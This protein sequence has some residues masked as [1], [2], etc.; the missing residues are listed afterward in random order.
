LTQTTKKRPKPQGGTGPFLYVVFHGEFAF[1]DIEKEKFLMALAPALNEHAYM[2]GPWLGEVHIPKGSGLEL[3]GVIEE[4]RPSPDPDVSILDGWITMFHSKAVKPT[5]TKSAWM[6]IKLPRP[7][8]A[9]GYSPN[10]LIPGSITVTKPKGLAP[11]PPHSQPLVLILQYRMY[12]GRRKVVP[13]LCLVSEYRMPAMVSG[14]ALPWVAG[15]LPDQSSYSLHIFGE[16]DFVPANPSQ[17]AERAFHLA[18]ALMGVEAAEE[19]PTLMRKTPVK[20]TKSDLCPPL[21]DQEIS[22]SLSDRLTALAKLATASPP[23][24]W[25]PRAANKKCD[26][27]GCGPLG[28]G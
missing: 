11:A 22:L 9:W 16:L 28:G 18:A 5:N 13:R 8:K 25:Q 10:P 15:L 7:W 4:D 2:A 23:P 6:Q 17:H 12:P 1:I 24:I 3:T 27:Y 20:S 19:L 21:R 26:A 14:M